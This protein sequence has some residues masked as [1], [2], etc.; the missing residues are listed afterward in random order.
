M[1]K[2][3][4]GLYC[5]VLGLCQVL[6][7]GGVQA[8]CE[9]PT[10]KLQLNGSGLDVVHRVLLHPNG[11]YYAAG[12]GNS[13]SM[14]HDL[15]LARFTEAGSI[16]WV[17][18]IDVEGDDGGQSMYL[19]VG[20]SGALYLGATLDGI[21]TN[22]EDG[23]LVKLD[24]NGNVLWARRVLPMAFYCQVRA[25]VERPDGEVIVVGSANSIGAGNADAWAARLTANGD[26]V[27]LRSYGWAGQDHFTHVELLGD[28]SF[29]AC[30]Q[31]MGQTGGVRKAMVAHI[32]SNGVPLGCVLHNGGVSDNYNHGVSNGDGTY[33]YVGFTESYGAG[34][35]DVLAVL[36]DSVGNRI[37]SRTYGTAAAEEGLSAVVDPNGGWR[38]AAFQGLNR[39]AHVLRVM[40]NGDL[41]S[42]I[43]LVDVSIHQTA[44]WAQVIERAA[45]GGYF[46][47]GSEGLFGLAGLSIVKLDACA[48][49]SCGSIEETWIV[50]APVIP[51]LTPQL[52]VSATSSNVSVVVPTVVDI[53]GVWSSLSESVP[54]DTCEVA[55][56]T[57]ALGVCLGLP[58]EIEVLDN[59]A[60]SSGAV[61]TWDMGDGTVLTDADSVSYVYS[62]EGTYQ[63]NLT[64]TDASSGCSDT[65]AFTVNASVVVQPAL[66]PD[67]VICPGAAQVLSAG[68]PGGAG[69]LWSDGSTTSTI[70]VASEG[71]YWV[72][73]QQGG[74]TLSDTVSLSVPLMPELLAIGDTLLCNDQLFIAEVDSG[75]AAVVWSDGSSGSSIQI[76]QPGI[77][78]VTGVWDSCTSTDTLWVEVVE[79]PEVDLGADQL[80]CPGET[81]TL[82][83]G[84]TGWDHLWSDGTQ[85]QS[86]EVAE[87]GAVW[88]IVGPQGCTATDTVQIITP[89]LPEV[90]LGPDMLLCDQEVVSFGPFSGDSILWFTGASVPQ[91]TIAD[92]ALVWVVVT[93]QGCAVSD[94]VIVAHGMAPDVVLP[95]DTII[96]GDGPWELVPVITSDADDWVWSTGADDPTIQ[97]DGSGSYWVLVS[98]DCGMASDTISVQMVAEPL[99][100]LGPDRL[101]CGDTAAVL[102]SGYPAALSTWNDT[103]SA[104]QLTVSEAGVYW[105]EV[106]MNGC[107]GR[108]T[109]QVTWMPLPHIVLPPDTLLCEAMD[110]VEVEVLELV[111]DEIAWSTG[112]AGS[113]LIISGSGLYVASAINACGV[114]SDSIMVTVSLPQAVDTLASTCSDETVLQLPVG[115][116]SVL[117]SNGSV[118][119]TIRV[120][121]G[122]YTWSAVD[123][124]GCNRSGFIRVVDDPNSDGNVFVPNVF[125]PNED[126]VN[127]GF[128]AYGADAGPYRLSVYNRWGQEIWTSTDPEQSWNG[129]VGGEAVP[130]GT[131]IYVLEHWNTCLTKE[132]GNVRYG[133]VTLLR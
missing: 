78:T 61:W 22:Q 107:V 121:M 35:R 105:V 58:V 80:I 52:P 91:I 104:E 120:P 26:L 75:W 94:S 126:D 68:D 77:Y 57:P 82:S 13:F 86:V 7:Y 65:V 24:E 118:E 73:F 55:L 67:L 43:D 56:T 74:C 14:D 49:T 27:W 38:I 6:L 23:S 16:V 114:A 81:L 110:L 115:Y 127:D 92:E 21:V 40:P 59:T 79:L 29:T 32:G 130:A 51:Q 128:R 117:W 123:Q 62:A 119:P 96:C 4:F 12:Y 112:A 125:T 113:V 11:D 124:T 103:I 102:S 45:N 72:V 54:C 63:G 95:T 93:V 46:L 64:V 34:G 50:T 133:H 1:G 85:G 71:D 106:D 48:E 66:G 47:A 10:F 30:S 116:G 28:G 44:S 20:P 2:E 36:T 108:D 87:T 122:V 41:D 70:E 37:W 100:D 109:V 17:K 101:L 131:Y 111:G 8:Q 9:Q 69:V 15:I 88:V 90:D 18:R 19:A 53:T 3:R 99:V 42:V 129:K 33:L 5:I 60:W 98:N 25:I 31:S 39:T 89:Q 97:V 83:T 132:G 76:T 84:L